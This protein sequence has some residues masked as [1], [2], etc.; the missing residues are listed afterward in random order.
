MNNP[1]VEVA[2]KY[3]PHIMDC[4]HAMNHGD[5]DR[6]WL[7]WEKFKEID[8]PLAKAVGARLFLHDDRI[9]EGRQLLLDALTKT[10]N[11]DNA[12]SAYLVEYC[13]VFL[14]DFPT[15]ADLENQIKKALSINS[16][17]STFNCLPLFERMD[18][19]ASHGA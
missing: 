7:L 16:P 10:G 12:A 6:A 5:L 17:V 11:K 3:V 14:I 13:K 18:Q 4:A 9:A 2:K 15:Q 8:N 19:Q 1:K